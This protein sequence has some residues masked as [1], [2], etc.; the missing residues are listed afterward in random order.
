MNCASSF[1]EPMKCRLV[2]TLP[3]GNS[4]AYEIK[5]DGYRLL[6]IKEG[7]QVCLRSRNQ[8]DLTDRFP[9]IREA[10]RQQRQ[11]SLILDGELVAFDSSGQPSF[12]SLQNS[13]QNRPQLAYYVF[14]LLEVQGR[15]LIALPWRQRRVRL[16]KAITPTSC[17]A[18]SPV[19]QESPETFLDRIQTEDLEGA[20]AK[21]TDSLYEPGKRSGAWVKLKCHLE[22][23]FV[24]GGFSE[25]AGSR[26]HFGALLVGY[27]K[28]N[29]LYFAAKVGSGF[30][31][32]KLAELFHKFEPDRI[33]ECPFIN[34]PETKGSR[35]SPGLT[36]SEMK[37]CT[38]I[39]PKWVCQVRF[40]EWTADDHLRQPSFLGLREDVAS[41]EVRREVAS[42]AVGSFAE[43]K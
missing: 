41:E 25:P 35:W 17:L 32:K 39:R 2:K 9:E 8:K 12:Q 40:S 3:A 4:W 23:E 29:D 5:Y 20:I 18:L 43:S 21:R 24:I 15:S 19:F 42:E 38:W 1:I 27:Y 36:A 6:A 31:E 7:D 11:S 33:S 26:K 13:D 16:E 28:D 10:V 30:T 37:R 34:L 14:D 22:Q